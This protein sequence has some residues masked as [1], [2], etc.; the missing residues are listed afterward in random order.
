[1]EADK[2][3]A[4]LSELEVK[5]W[6]LSTHIDGNYDRCACLKL[7]LSNHYFF[8]PQKESALWVLEG[9]L[10]KQLEARGL[11]REVYQHFGFALCQV[12]IIDPTRETYMKYPGG[13][14]DDELTSLL[15][16]C[17]V[18]PAHDQQPTPQGETT[19]SGK[20]WNDE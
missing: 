4:A 6:P 11:R 19:A 9:W 8:Y 20:K 12:T 14:C 17:L 10:R 2:L 1:M 13:W 15:Q 16:A 3:M 5:G 18:V 7:A